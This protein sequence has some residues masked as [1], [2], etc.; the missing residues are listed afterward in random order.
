MS[1]ISYLAKIVVVGISLLFPLIP[2]SLLPAASVTVSQCAQP[3][4]HVDHASFTATQLAQYGLPQRHSGE[5]QAHWQQVVRAAKTRICQGK[6]GTRSHQPLLPPHPSITATASTVSDEE[7][8]NW[9]GNIANE[10]DYTEA[11]GEW[12]VPCLTLL[13][14]DDGASAWVGLGGSRNDGGGNLVQ[15]GSSSL[16]FSNFPGHWYAEYYAW[17]E[18]YPNDPTDIIAFSVNCGATM[19][20]DVWQDYTKGTPVQAN[21]FISDWTSG[22]YW[23]AYN[24]QAFANDSTA[25]WIVERGNGNSGNLADFHTAQF[26]GCYAVR[27]GNTLS[28]INL[29]HNYT[30][31]IWNGHTLARVGPLY[32]DHGDSWANFAVNWV[33]SH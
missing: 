6:P 16:E 21:M 15:A 33:A 5:S 25:E 10:Y 19:Y 22:Q 28:P 4:Q 32:P 7:Y 29:P 8:T 9:A 14:H 23:G 12:T 18:D 20:A 1:F 26:T 3:P 27:Y 31:M 24:T 17:I 30:T 13:L 2:R 11:V